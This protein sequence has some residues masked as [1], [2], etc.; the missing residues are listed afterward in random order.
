MAA[1]SSENKLRAV[2]IDGPAG[3]GK[4]TV[5][6]ALAARLGWRYVDTGAMY[7]AATLE[8]VRRGVEVESAAPEEIARCAREARIEL[9]DRKDGQRVSLD[10]E[11]VTAAIRQP[12]LTRRVRYV[13]RCAP[14]RAELVKKQR[15]AALAR[16]VVMEGRD[17]G[18]VVMPD[19][20]VKFYLDATIEERARRRARDLER[21]GREVTIEAVTEE[22]LS[23]DESDTGRAASPLVPAPDAEIVDTTGL[24]AEE[25]VDLL[26]RRV[27]ERIGAEREP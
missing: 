9:R 18:T 20:A 14:A 4:S 23:R 6:K 3:A 19:A 13:A 15:A 1:S 2:A 21:A 26:E 22:I 24:S 25:V 10:G 17:I 12:E 5:A 8:A 7:R 16:P 27:R 11:D